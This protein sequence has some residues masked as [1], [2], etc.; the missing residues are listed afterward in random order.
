M[1][2]GLEYVVAAY[3]IWFC[4]FAVYIFIIKRRMIIASQTVEAIKQRV[5]ESSEIPDIT[6]NIEN[7]E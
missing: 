4:T 2:I 6:G 5:S 3:V 7:Q 1:I